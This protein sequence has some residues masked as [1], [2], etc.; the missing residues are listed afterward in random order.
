MPQQIVSGIHTRQWARS[1]IVADPTDPYLN[2]S[3]PC[4]YILPKLYSPG[5]TTLSGY[6]I[7]AFS[8]HRCS[9]L[10]KPSPSDSN[11]LSL[12]ERESHTLHNTPHMILMYGWVGGEG[13]CYRHT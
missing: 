1:Y 12:P 4:I 2:L 6:I 5:S 7:L 3:E 10:E 9:T 13:G 11:T 8:S